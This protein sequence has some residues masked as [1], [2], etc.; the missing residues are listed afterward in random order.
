MKWNEELSR[1]LK[2]VDDDTYKALCNSMENLECHANKILSQ[3]DWYVSEG[4][5]DINIIETIEIL[6]NIFPMKE[7]LLKGTAGINNLQI[8]N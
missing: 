6:A 2:E 7:S 1:N 8:M 4:I 3:Q 5:L